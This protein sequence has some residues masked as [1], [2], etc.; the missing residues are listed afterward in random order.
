VT[1]QHFGVLRPPPTAQ[2][3]IVPLLQPSSA[4]VHHLNVYAYHI[5]PLY[6]TVHIAVLTAMPLHLP[7]TRMFEFQVASIS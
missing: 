4:I 6:N 3:I 7:F 5:L 1:Y 2:T